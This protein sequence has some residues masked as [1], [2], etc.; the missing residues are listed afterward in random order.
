MTLN[1]RKIVTYVEDIFS[2]GG[3]PGGPVR[4]AGVAAIIKTHKQAR[5]RNF[6]IFSPIC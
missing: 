3:R 1:L 2:E 5:N 4:L 6:E